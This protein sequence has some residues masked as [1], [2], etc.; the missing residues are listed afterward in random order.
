MS[1]NTRMCNF[2]LP[3]APVI[4]VFFSV[5]DELTN[6]MM[7]Q[8]TSIIPLLS[9]LN[10]VNICIFLVKSCTFLTFSNKYISYQHSLIR[11]STEHRKSC[12]VKFPCPFEFILQLKSKD[13]KFLL[14]KSAI[15]LISVLHFF[16]H[17]GY[18]QITPV[19][20]L[21]RIRKEC[22]V[23]IHVMICFKVIM[24]WSMFRHNVEN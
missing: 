8:I 6:C 21:S 23:G 5:F 10:R 1:F 15:R 20:L 24:I 12:F 18:A 13:I 19:V 17:T 4:S 3:G 16:I 9:S 11:R 7:L 22:K 2:I 14:D